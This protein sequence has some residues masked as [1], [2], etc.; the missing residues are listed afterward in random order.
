MRRFQQSLATFGRKQ[1]AAVILSAIVLSGSALLGMTGPADAKKY[2]YYQYHY[3][4]EC[5]SGWWLV[6]DGSRYT[7][8]SDGKFR[9]SWQTRCRKWTVRTPS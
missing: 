3:E 9:P 7:Y 8:P 2:R 5:R 4:Y 6:R 1:R